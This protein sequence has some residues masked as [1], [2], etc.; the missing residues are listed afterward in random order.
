MWRGGPV[1]RMCA[2]TVAVG[3][4]DVAEAH[5]TPVLSNVLHARNPRRRL[6]SADA[7]DCGSP[8]P[9]QSVSS[10]MPP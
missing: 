6:A 9:S 8:S 3:R 1:D 4:T 5:S 2:Y 7:A 10:K